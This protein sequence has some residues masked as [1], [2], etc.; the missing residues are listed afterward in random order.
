[1]L[2]KL[3][4]KQ[5]LAWEAFDELEPI[6]G[7]RG[8]WQAA[9]I[10]SMLMNL[11]GKRARTSD[12]LLEFGEE[13]EVPPAPAPQRQTWQEQKMIGMMFAAASAKGGRK[14]HWKK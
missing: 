11:A 3:P 14:K 5:L 10:C 4:F 6:G 2:R 12:C 8:D 13:R 7:R 9:S 1:M